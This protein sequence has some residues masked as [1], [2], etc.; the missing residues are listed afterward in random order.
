MV[1]TH[2]LPS[3]VFLLLVPLASSPKWAV[4]L[5]LL[6]ETF[7]EMDVPTRQSYVAAVVKPYE[8]P[9]A[10]GFTSVIRTGAWAVASSLSGLVMQRLAFSAPLV[11]GGGLKIVYDLLL[12]R[13][14]RHLKPPEELATHPS[15]EGA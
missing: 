12:Y 15:A 3:S 10:S 5:F 9:Y 2:L 13:K 6:R 14:F 11:I 1:F 4:A 8:R 7:V